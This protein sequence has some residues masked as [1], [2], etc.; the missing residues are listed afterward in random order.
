LSDSAPFRHTSSGEVRRRGLVEGL[1]LRAGHDDYVIYRDQVAGLEYL[2][3]S[4]DL[5]EDG[6]LVSLGPYEHRVYWEFREVGDTTGAYAALARRLDGA[7]VRGVAAA[8]EELRT[9]PLRSAVMGLVV[10]ARPALEGE[11]PAD[12]PEVEAA[13]CRVLDEAAQAGQAIDRRRA[14][15]SLPGDL[16]GMAAAATALDR[17]PPTFDVGWLAVWAALRRFPGGRLAGLHPERLPLDGAEV[18]SRL[19]PILIRHAAVIREWGKTRGSAGGL[20]RM[21]TKLLEDED[22]AALLSLHEHRGVLWF[23][24]DGFRSLI[25]GLVVGGLLGSRSRALSERAGELMAAAERAE[26]RSG[27]RLQRLL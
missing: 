21:L 4:R 27:Y 13:F 14:L 6:L 1:G 26:E 12:D 19:L 24:R 7:G 22:V 10:A 9:E 23:D 15:T 25:R 11:A 5:A 16:A 20:R 17:R 18:W 3:R 8:L 2:R